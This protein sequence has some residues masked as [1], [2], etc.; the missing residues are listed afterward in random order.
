MMMCTCFRGWVYGNSTRPKLLRTSS[1][2][3]DSSGAAHPPRLRGIGVQ[4]LTAHNS[5]TVGLPILAR[6]IF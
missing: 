1:R 5:Y 2:E 6:H 4:M 3:I